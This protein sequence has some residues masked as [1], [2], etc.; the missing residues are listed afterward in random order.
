MKA[1][2]IFLLLT[3]AGPALAE[4][5][6]ASPAAPAQD[7]Y[8]GGGKPYIYDSNSPGLMKGFTP[9]T[10][11]TILPIIDGVPGSSAP[12]SSAPIASA[13]A[14]KIKLWRVGPAPLQK[15]APPPPKPGLG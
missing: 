13:P 4:T 9:P 14:P 7:S 3:M 15:P 10:P 11:V 8:Y 12:V 2:S 6:A 1:A 5:P